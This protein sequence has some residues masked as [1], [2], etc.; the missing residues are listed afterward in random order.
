[1]AAIK[2]YRSCPLKKRPV[3]A[4]NYDEMPSAVAFV[5]TALPHLPEQEEPVNLCI[6]SKRLRLSLDD[7]D[8]KIIDNNNDS[9]SRPLRDITS[10]EHHHQQQQ[11]VPL[12][13]SAAIKMEP[14]FTTE[15]VIP[16]SMP[17]PTIIKQ[18]PILYAEYSPPHSEYNYTIAQHPHPNH[19][20]LHHHQQHQEQHHHQHQHI[21]DEHQHRYMPSNQYHHTI[22]TSASPSSVSGATAI[23]VAATAA[24]AAVAAASAAAVHAATNTAA[25]PGSGPNHILQH[26][27][28]QHLM[29]LE[30]HPHARCFA[31]S[32]SP[33]SLN[34]ET[35]SPRSPISPAQST[36]SISEEMYQQYPLCHRAIRLQRP[37]QQQ[38][39]NPALSSHIPQHMSHHHLQQSHQHNHHNQLHSSNE[40]LSIASA[41][42]S[43]SST[44]NT[45]TTTTSSTGI[46]PRYQCQS[47]NK[48]Y[49]T[50]SGLN[51]HEQFHCQ[52]T[53]GN[54]AKKSYSCPTCGKINKSA[55]AMKMHMRTHTLPNKCHICDK[56]FSRPWLLQGHIRT[57]TGEKPFSCE[58]CSRA[59]ADRSNLRAHM[60]T[61]SDVKKYSCDACAKTF[62]RVS[63]LHKHAESGCP[64][65]LKEESPRHSPY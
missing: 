26:K 56:A 25:P 65:S 12:N 34:S 28:R 52:L 18:E 55:S 59:F 47:C 63:L 16:A 14:I 30:L 7:A 37:Q 21:V 36:D 20:Q 2:N 62:S 4:I 1:M 50:Y 13:Y 33:L 32:M 22:T 39:Q 61:H 10:V 9:E 45:T 49:S 31:D 43:S 5:A 46:A 41:P 42:T 27:Q 8:T 19:H 6:N 40:D 51:K 23:G 15:T 48:S 29:M 54:Q 60:Q 38:D 64:G 11:Q 44:I 57:H 35:G 3:P 58:Y 53:E 24:A 17:L